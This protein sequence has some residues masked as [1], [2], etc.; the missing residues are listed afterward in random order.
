MQEPEPADLDQPPLPPI[1]RI[2]VACDGTC[3][4]LLFSMRLIH[5]QRAFYGN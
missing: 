2:V 4:I 5:K 1:K 3:Y